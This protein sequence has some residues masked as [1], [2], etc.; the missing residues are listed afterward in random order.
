MISM[1]ISLGLG[2]VL[3][4]T[5]TTP[6]VE[7]ITKQ[8]IVEK[9][10][11]QEK[12][13]EKIVKDVQIVQGPIKTVI[14]EKRPDGTTIETKIDNSGSETKSKEVVDITKEKEIRSE[15]K[16]STETQ[17]NPK[18]DWLIGFSV[19]YPTSKIF[20]GEYLQPKMDLSVRYR[21]FKDVYVG[22]S[23]GFSLD[24]KQVFV[25]FGINVGI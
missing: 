21:I 22:P 4:K 15:T 23:T 17:S 24:S 7:I 25:G 3:A 10:V 11:I 20:K 12:I 14:I 9:I 5:L 18:K 13:V 16:T 8:E 19:E 6:E 2:F 1:V